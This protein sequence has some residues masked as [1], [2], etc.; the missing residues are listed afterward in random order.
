MR[1]LTIEDPNLNE[2]N[3]FHREFYQLNSHNPQKED[4]LAVRSDEEQVT[5]F[6]KEDEK[7]IDE[8][9]ILIGGDDNIIV[10]L[11]ER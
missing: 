9:L 3:N 8:L 10:Q 4:Y 11:K 6:V 1:V 5:L 7:T 2:R